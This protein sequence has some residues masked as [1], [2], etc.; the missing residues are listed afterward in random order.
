MMGALE[1]AK[2]I[3]ASF[4]ARYWS[5]VSKILRGYFITAL[6]VLILITSGG[7]FGYLS[8]AYQQTKGDYTIVEKQTGVLKNKKERYD[9]NIQGYQT[10]KEQ[11]DNNI[12]SLIQ[13]LSNNKIQYTDTSGQLITTQSSTARKLYEKQLNEN[14]KRRDELTIKIDALSDS[15]TTIDMAIFE[16]ESQN[17][18]G[19]LGPLKYIAGIFGT[20]MD[21]VV[22]YFIFLLIF[23]FDPLAVLLFV[24]LNMIIRKEGGMYEEDNENPGPFDDGG[25]NN[26]PKT[27]IIE[28]TPEEIKEDIEYLQKNMLAALK[29]PDALQKA[30]LEGEI[31]PE[32]S[33]E[34]TEELR[35][36]ALLIEEESIKEIAES[37]KFVEQLVEDFEH[38]IE[39]VQEEIEPE[40]EEI[41]PEQ[42]KKEDEHEFYHGEGIIPEVMPEIIPEIIPEPASEQVS[43]PNITKR[44]AN[45]RG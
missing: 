21:T 24:S 28:S 5:A 26:K 39:S 22:K 12:N 30:K 10:E 1:F 45:Y 32:T 11:S 35:Q 25:K 16:L 31:E 8:D 33:K 7:I 13:A 23:V 38:N 44:S 3:V 41:E 15:S 4:L 40:Q 27:K 36:M 20:D 29:I 42:E 9:L 14:Q 34:A 17:I 43:G 6:F 2:I 19:E 18:Q 37:E